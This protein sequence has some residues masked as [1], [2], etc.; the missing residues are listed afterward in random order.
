MGIIFPDE[1]GLEVEEGSVRTAEAETQKAVMD[2]YYYALLGQ[3]PPF[4][5]L[6]NDGGLPPIKPFTCGRNVLITRLLAIAKLE[7]E[8]FK[9]GTGQ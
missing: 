7:K 6:H 5:L 1:L 4:L 3:L 2:C 8:R 9:D